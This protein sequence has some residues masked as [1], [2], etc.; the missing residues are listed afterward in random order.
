MDKVKFVCGQQTDES[1]QDLLSKYKI[2]VSKEGYSKTVVV[3]NFVTFIINDKGISYF[4]NGGLNSRF[5]RHVCGD[6]MIVLE[7]ETIHI[8]SHRETIYSLNFGSEEE[9]RLVFLELQP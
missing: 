6:W 3:G 2:S 7:K 8:Y 4:G 9:A 1:Y 5:G